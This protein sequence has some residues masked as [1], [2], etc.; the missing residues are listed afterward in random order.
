MTHR[1][2]VEILGLSEAREHDDLTHVSYSEPHL[3]PIRWTTPVGPPIPEVL[4]AVDPR[5]TCASR[6]D[7]RATK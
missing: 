1:H 5:L 2:Y 3:H 4:P 7:S 6:A